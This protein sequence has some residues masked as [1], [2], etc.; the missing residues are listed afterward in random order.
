MTLTTI[1][2]AALGDTINLSTEV[3][4]L[5]PL[6]NGGTNATSIPATNLASG[7]TGTLATG[8]GGTGATSFSPGKLLQAARTVLSSSAETTSGSFS[9]VLTSASFT[10][11]SSSNSL[12]V[13]VPV[14]VKVRGNGSTATPECYV[15]IT[16]NEGTELNAN[17][18]Y[19]SDIANNN[20]AR[21]E[22]TGTLTALYS[23]NSTSPVIY[24]Q[25]KASSGAIQ[26]KGNDNISGGCTVSNIILQE[27]SA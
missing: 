9:T 14:N 21:V 20:N 26:M 25:Y 23:P 24:L 8:N 3:T 22:N 19:F 11:A 13:T 15:R 17:M 5:L 1:N 10:M 12:L 18:F 16:N 27:I 7:V 4:G 2:L 6:A